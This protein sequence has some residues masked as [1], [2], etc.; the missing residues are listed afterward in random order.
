MDSDTK[1]KPA[2]YSARKMYARR[3]ILRG[4]VLLG[5]ALLGSGCALDL[6]TRAD[7]VRVKVP[8]NHLVC[9]IP[10]QG[11]DFAWLPD[12]KQI[13]YASNQGLFVVNIQSKQQ[14]WKQK[15][16]PGHSYTEAHTVAWSRDGTRLIYITDT[17]FLIQ[18]ALNG[19]NLW[20]HSLPNSTTR[21]VALS[22]DGTHI[23]FTQ[24]QTPPPHQS[25]AEFVQ[26]WDVSAQRLLSQ[27][28]LASSKSMFAWSPDSTLL[29]INDPDGSVQVH[30]GSEGRLLW[31]YAAPSSAGPLTLLSWS[32]D[33]SALA[34]SSQEYSNKE[35]WGSGMLAAAMSVFRS[36]LR[37]APM[38]PIA[39]TG[40][41]PG[42][43][44]A[45]VWPLRLSVS[46]AQPWSF[47]PVRQ[48]NSSFPASL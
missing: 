35:C 22:P 40:A 33:S 14:Q 8:L 15:N 42:H 1:Q 25:S 5:G 3:S 36:R 4:G 17:A 47:A 27:Y 28:P 34:F 45:D 12:N 13:A 37:S 26:I 9:D 44:T 32:P 19:Y 16:W 43:P 48:E 18:N 11:I 41:L 20:T 38:R 46:I 39:R 21:A 31:H 2:P 23:A 24:A 10:W 7:T 30:D 29:A 6:A